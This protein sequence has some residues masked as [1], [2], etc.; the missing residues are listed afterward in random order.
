MRDPQ[1][2]LHKHVGAVERRN[3]SNR[4]FWNQQRWGCAAKIRGNWYF[5]S[6][7]PNRLLTMKLCRDKDVA[8]ACPYTL[9][10]GLPAFVEIDAPS[11]GRQVG[12]IYSNTF[13]NH[14][15]FQ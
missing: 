8:L 2:F 4:K 11:G 13:K 15:F 5:D 14:E 7:G 3:I 10:Y 6:S 1:M 12:P 9:V